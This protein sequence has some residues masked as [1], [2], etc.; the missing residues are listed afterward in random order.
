MS[1]KRL[2]CGIGG[3]AATLAWGANPC[4]VKPT[5]STHVQ[6]ITATNGLP[7]LTE[8]LGPEVGDA[9]QQA[10][11]AYR[12][13]PPIRSARSQPPLPPRPPPRGRGRGW[14]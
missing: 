1:M 9:L 7:D 8:A 3:L 4:N 5:I 6:V 10:Q 2:I 12:R 14:A 13:W 11:A